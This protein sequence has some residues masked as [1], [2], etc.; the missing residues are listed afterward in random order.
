MIAIFFKEKA[1]SRMQ[2]YQILFF[3][4]IQSV[5]DTKPQPKILEIKTEV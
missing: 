1:V 2:I 3:I 5:L 4:S